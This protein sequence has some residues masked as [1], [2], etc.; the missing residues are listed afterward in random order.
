MLKILFEA[1]RWVNLPYTILLGAMGAYWLTVILGFLDIEVF[2]I[3][4][5]LDVDTELDF[6]SMLSVLNVGAVPFSIWL[7]IFILQ[8]WLYS[9]LANMAFDAIFPALPD[10]V[11]FLLCAVIFIPISAMMAKFFTAPLK[12]AFEGRSFSKSDIVGKECLVTSSQVTQTFGTAEVLLDRVPQ[13][14]DIRAKPED[15]FKKG[16]TALIY[17]YDEE[18]DVFYVTNM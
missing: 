13:L 17:S 7:S 11:R 18:R 6:G 12:S 16:D 5:D 14:I 10:V 1:I 3:D 9:I 15:G 2:D 8:M 4:L